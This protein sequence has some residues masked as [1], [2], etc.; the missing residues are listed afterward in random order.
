MIV[1]PHGSHIHENLLNS[2]LPLAAHPSWL[3]LRQFCRKNLP[4]G[5]RNQ[6]FTYTC[7]VLPYIALRLDYHF[8]TINEQH[9]QTNHNLQKNSRVCQRRWL[10]LVTLI[11]VFSSVLSSML[12]WTLWNCGKL[13]ERSLKQTIL[14]ITCY[15]HM[16]KIP[17][18]EWREIELV[19]YYNFHCC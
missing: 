19:A 6:L 12:Y 7:L 14:N 9:K 18:R 5:L 3:C 10:G 16:P 1:L 13:V 15:L 8:D 17:V 4:M 2:S 11:E